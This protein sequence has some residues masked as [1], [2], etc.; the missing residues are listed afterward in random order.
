MIVREWMEIICRHCGKGFDLPEQPERNKVAM[1]PGLERLQGIRDE[2][3][4]NK[5]SKLASASRT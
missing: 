5:F 3:F 2:D 1:R 4:G